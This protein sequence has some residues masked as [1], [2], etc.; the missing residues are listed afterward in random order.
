MRRLMGCG[1]LGLAE[2]GLLLLV[3]QL[4]PLLGASAAAE[5]YR[6]VLILPRQLGLDPL[7]INSASGAMIAASA[8]FHALITPS[9]PAV[10]S[11]RM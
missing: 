6:L 9:V 5:G 11:F 10:S 4:V 2:L 8:T 1:S 7:R 3:A